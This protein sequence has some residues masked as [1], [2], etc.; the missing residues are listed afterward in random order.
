M[1]VEALV[2][3]IM[4][5]RIAEGSTW[6]TWHS[7]QTMNE[8]ET[9]AMLHRILFKRGTFTAYESIALANAIFYFKT[10]WVCVDG[11]WAHWSRIEGETENQIL[12][13][14]LNEPKKGG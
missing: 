1:S 12:F 13:A 11:G 9:V 4:G 10:G 7:V 14:F 2:E 8:L 6:D 5:V 3:D